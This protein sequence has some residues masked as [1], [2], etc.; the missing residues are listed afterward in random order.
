LLHVVVDKTTPIAIAFV[1]AQTTPAWFDIK[2]AER[3][4]L[5]FS[6]LFLR[7][8]EYLVD[9]PGGI[10]FFSRA[11][12][13]SNDFHISSLHVWSVYGLFCTLCVHLK[14]SHQKE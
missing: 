5:R 2:I 7:P 3:P 6:A 8:F 4:G 1:T 12:D 14:F 10:A 11:S 9:G 13:K